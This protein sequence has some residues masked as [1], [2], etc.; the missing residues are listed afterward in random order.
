M[1]RVLEELATRLDRHVEA[2]REL[3]FAGA[4]TPTEAEAVRLEAE[5]AESALKALLLD[6]APHLNRIPPDSL[7][8]LRPKRTG[9]ITQRLRFR[10]RH[11]KP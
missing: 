11:N 1:S 7:R 3:P 4:Q 6:L 5:A 10:S 9:G 2:Q 8:S